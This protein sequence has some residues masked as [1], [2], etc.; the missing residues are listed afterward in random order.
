MGPWK[1]QA[2]QVGQA[3]VERHGRVGDEPQVVGASVPYSHEP[4]V[5]GLSGEVGDLP[6]GGVDHV[7]Q[8]A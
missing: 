4:G 2:R 3:V 7:D 8:F 5:D 6:G 1:L